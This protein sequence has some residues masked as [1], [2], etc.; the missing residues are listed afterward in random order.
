MIRLNK[1]KR[2]IPG[3]FSGQRGRRLGEGGALLLPGHARALQIFF[4]QLPHRDLHIRARHVALR[5]RFARA[6]ERASRQASCPRGPA[7]RGSGRFEVYVPV[8]PCQR[9]K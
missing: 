1:A 9:G 4:V 2:Q 8:K 3:Y 5:S 6:A 7:A